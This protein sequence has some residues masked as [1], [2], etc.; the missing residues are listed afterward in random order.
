MKLSK[1]KTVSKYFLYTLLVVC[2]YSCDKSEYQQFKEMN[3]PVILVGESK[4]GDILLID[5]KGSKVVLNRDYYIAKI[6]SDTYN[7]NDTINYNNYH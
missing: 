3:S 5:S 2:F 7:V 6:I 1:V 4:D